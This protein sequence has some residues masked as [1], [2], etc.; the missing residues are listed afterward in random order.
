MSCLAFKPAHD[1]AAYWF[2]DRY[3]QHLGHDIERLPGL[4]GRRVAWRETW[5][6]HAS[7]YNL[8]WRG[9][10]ASTGPRQII[11]KAAV[12]VL[13]CCLGEV[14]QQCRGPRL[15]SRLDS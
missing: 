11:N 15:F 1:A 4:P 6:A 14:G 2:V 7:L 5:A 9:E 8:R 10:N 3:F 13:L 12:R